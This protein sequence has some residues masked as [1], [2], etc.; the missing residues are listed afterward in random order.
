MCCGQMGHLL[1]PRPLQFL[2]NG[3][4]AKFCFLIHFLAWVHYA[5]SS[6]APLRRCR[7]TGLCA[8]EQMVLAELGGGWSSSLKIFLVSKRNFH[9][10]L[11]PLLLG[12]C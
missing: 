10:S 7:L 6:N 2:E 12:L 5:A 9:L 1:V 4:N 11:G 8:A 3:T